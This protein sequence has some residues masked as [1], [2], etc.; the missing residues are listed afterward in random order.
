MEEQ[1]ISETLK[2]VDII[3]HLRGNMT[4][5]ET[6]TLRCESCAEETE[7][8]FFFGTPAAGD[9]VTATS[10]QCL[11]CGKKTSFTKKD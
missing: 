4:T 7:H 3:T 5:F 10:K 11:L 9:F 8:Q 2:F 6:R 1:I